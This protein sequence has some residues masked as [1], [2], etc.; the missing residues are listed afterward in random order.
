MPSAPTPGVGRP[1]IMPRLEPDVWAR[2]TLAPR[3]VSPADPATAHAI[4]LRAIRDG[5]AVTAALEG[6]TVIGLVITRH[7]DDAARSDV[8]ALG[9]APEW[10]RRGLATRLLATR[11]EWTRP[12]DIEH[13]AL[14]TV[15]ERDPI[16]PLDVGA[17]MGIAR[18]L[19]TGAGFD[20]GSPGGDIGAAD[21]V[22]IRGRRTDLRGA[23]D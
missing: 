22:A 20:I 14:V 4:I 23:T 18:R 7:A 16:E 12:G 19:L 8:L 17:R 1:S 9:V 11:L 6:T 21:P 13:E 10:R 5:A 2:L 3:V 15:A